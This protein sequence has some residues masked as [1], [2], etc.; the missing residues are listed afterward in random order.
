MKVIKKEGL[1]KIMKIIEGKHNSIDAIING[2]KGQGK[3]QLDT[4]K[5]QRRKTIRRN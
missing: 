2:I 4:I 1:L 3:K 5:D